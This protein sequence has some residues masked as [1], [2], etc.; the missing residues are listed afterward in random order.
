M[1]SVRLLLLATVLVCS[2]LTLLL[3]PAR[4][5]KRK[6]RVAWFDGIDVSHHQGKINWRLVAKNPS[7]RFVYIKATEG[8]TIVDSRYRY[9][10]TQARKAGLPCGAYLFLSSTSSAKAQFRAFTRVVKKEDQDLVPVID[11]ERE[12]MRFWTKKEVHANVKLLI[13]LMKA[14]YGKAPII[15]SQFAYYN[16]QLAPTFNQYHLFLAKYSKGHP[17]IRGKGK[18]NI[19]QFTERGQINGIRGRVDLNRLVNGTTL[20]QLRLNDKPEEQVPPANAN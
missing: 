19:W 8:S 5:G 15:Y 18:N 11:V 14:H 17:T 16:E 6:A 3:V 9:N 12:N 2:A 4:A 7:V 10:I 1:K 13:K 20:D